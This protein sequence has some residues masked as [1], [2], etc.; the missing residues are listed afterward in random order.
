MRQQQQYYLQGV[1]ALT[2][3]LIGLSTHSTLSINN[4]N[5]T[6]TTITNNLNNFSNN[7]TATSIKYLIIWI[8]NLP[9]Q[10]FQSIIWMQLQPLYWV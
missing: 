8:V 5:A 2:T 6:W 4:L 3:N 7:L 9:I 1:Y 10:H